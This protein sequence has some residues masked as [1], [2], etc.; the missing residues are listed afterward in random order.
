MN[1]LTKKNFWMGFLNK[2]TLFLVLI[3]TGG[4]YV[5]GQDLSSYKNFQKLENTLQ[6]VVKANKDLA[7]IESIG[8]SAEGRDI[9]LI[10]IANR[11]G[12]D[13]SERPGLLVTANLEGDHLVGSELALQSMEYLLD[14][15][16][17]DESV[18][19]A[20]DEHVFYFLPRIN[21]DG[22]EKNFQGLSG[23]FR[24]NSTPYDGDNDGR[25]DEDGPEDLNADGLITIMRVKDPSGP[26]MIDPVNPGLMKIADPVKGESGAYSIYWEGIDNDGDGFVNED[27]AGGVDINRNFMHAYPYYK[28]DAGIH[29]V[30]ENET[31]ALIDWVIAN[32]N[33]ALML[34]FG[35]SDNLISPPDSRG[36]L[37]SDNGIALFQFA[38]KSLVDADKVGLM[39]S[40]GYGRQD[41][42]GMDFSMMGRSGGQDTGS[43]RSRRPARQPATV[44]DKDD[45]EFFTQISKKYKE[46]TGIESQP[47]VRKP[48]GAFF[49]YGYFQY[50]VPSFSTPGW[51]MG[52]PVD[53]VA[54]TEGERRP[55]ARRGGMPGRNNGDAEGM[56]ARAKKWLDKNEVNGFV[57]WQT[58]DHPEFEGVE[59]GG[60][61][62]MA[63]TNPPAALLEG[64]GEKHGKFILYL[65]GLYA[66]INIAE[67][68]V[69]NHGGGIF[70]I[71]AEIENAGFLPSSLA[72][73]VT[74][75]S[76]KPTMVQLGVDPEAILS[77]NN[78]TNFLQKLDGS[79]KRQ[80]YEWLIKGKSGDK[81]ELKVV[82][83]K[84]GSDISVIELK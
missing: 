2:S 57:E 12:A 42:G 54:P 58:V 19:K 72:H 35:E 34:S 61:I 49:E 65:S 68:S 32:R 7:R 84:G 1:T 17:S 27:P 29:M 71:K 38:D 33:I 36:E 21:P 64:L 46:I 60:F 81:I 18:K 77:G 26:Y 25:I 15:Y 75:R 63:L 10:T 37:S 8:K 69:V 5:Q 23:G 11:S 51:G 73:G 4:Q 74:S 22:A 66:D 55:S 82:S 30:S 52:V 24:T 39:S 28:P 41:F 9:W 13:F 47:P 53:T 76:V 43:A 16:N 20:L 40:R 6:S 78:K 70:R 44:V 3:F 56:D 80:E 14:N 83:Q 67:T 59:V 45:V 62:P 79:G 48:E 50:G 31:R